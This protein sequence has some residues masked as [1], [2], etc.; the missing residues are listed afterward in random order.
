MQHAGSEEKWV[1][2]YFKDEMTKELPNTFIIRHM[3]GCVWIGRLKHAA[4]ISRGQNGS[5]IFSTQHAF[6]ACCVFI[7]SSSS[8]FCSMFL[9]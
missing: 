3:C 9:F 5:I 7:E 2:V 1:K 6:K 8:C 4:L